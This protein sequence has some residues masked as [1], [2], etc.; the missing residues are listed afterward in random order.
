MKRSLARLLRYAYL[1]LVAVCGAY[2]G[3]HIVRQTGWYKDRLYHILVTGGAKEQLHAASALAQLN[4]QEHLLRAM[5]A[6]AP[7]V[8]DLAR[9]ALEHLWFNAAGDEAYQ[10]TQAAYK[11]AGEEKFDDALSIL[12]RLTSKYPKFAEGWN[13]RASVYWQMGDW[14]KSIADCERTLALNPNHYGAWQGIGIC[15][16]QLGNVAEACRSLRAALRI[17]PHDAPTRNSL[18]RCE[19]LLRMYPNPL[20]KPRR[21]EEWL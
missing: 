13:R 17:A 15:H 21:G 6:E 20:T 14:E 19:E 9:R 2:L 5:K 1:L 4:A 18:H 11:A 8:H 16:L 10:L 3:L 12:N 7:A